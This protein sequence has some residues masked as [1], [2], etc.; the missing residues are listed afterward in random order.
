MEESAG[1][2]VVVTPADIERVVEQVI[3][4]NK[5][6]LLEQRYGFPIGTLLGEIRKRLKWADG[7]EVKTEVDVQ[8]GRN[9]KERYRDLFVRLILAFG[10]T[11]SK[12]SSGKTGCI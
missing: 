3:E 9:H 11:W 8:V 1:V 12:R 5:S 7:K 10:F 4:E 6:K 2:G